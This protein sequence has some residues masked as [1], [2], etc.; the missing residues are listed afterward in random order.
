MATTRIRELLKAEEE[1]VA[2]VTAARKVREPLHSEEE[3]EEK[4][5]TS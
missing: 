3:E 5:N 2:T 4:P 1:A